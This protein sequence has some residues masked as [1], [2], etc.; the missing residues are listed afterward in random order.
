[1]ISIYTIKLLPDGPLTSTSHCIRS[2]LPNHQLGSSPNIARSYGAVGCLFTTI[3][4]AIL[5]YF[6]CL[7]PL[8]WRDVFWEYGTV[9]KQWILAMLSIFQPLD[10]RCPGSDQFG[11]LATLRYY[12]YT[13]LYV[14]TRTLLRTQLYSWRVGNC[15]LT[16][17]RCWGLL[18][19]CGLV[20]R[21]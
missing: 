17:S 18:P 13:N 12:L 10:F 3:S 9:V 11:T 6:I 2:L 14:F 16:D 21:F 19:G 8:S 1:M 7:N 5:G 4:R 20:P 15:W